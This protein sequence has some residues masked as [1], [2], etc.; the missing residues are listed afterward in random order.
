MSRLF[1]G[2]TIALDVL[3][4]SCAFETCETWIVS[5][6]WDHNTNSMSLHKSKCLTNVQRATANIFIDIKNIDTGKYEIIQKHCFQT[7]SNFSSEHFTFAN[8]YLDGRLSFNVSFAAWY[9]ASAQWTKRSSYT[10]DCFCWP[11]KCEI[12]VLMVGI[13]RTK[14]IESLGYYPSITRFRI[15]HVPS[16]T[17]WKNASDK[18][19]SMSPT[20]FTVLSLFLFLSHTHARTWTVTCRYLIMFMF[21]Q[22]GQWNAPF[23]HL[24]LVKTWQYNNKSKYS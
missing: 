14:S 19:V 24:F 18:N 12:N 23:G 11:I 1:N 3:F 9:S 4:H 6:I 15:N 21:L 5:F 7:N 8:I 17:V 10:V 20:P 22:C 2:I 13:V 16:F